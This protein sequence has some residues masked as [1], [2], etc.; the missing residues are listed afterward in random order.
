MCG[1][2]GS[3]PKPLGFKRVHESQSPIADLIFIHG[4]DGHREN[5]WK[6]KDTLWLEWLKDHLPDA[7]VSTY[8][9]NAKIFSAPKFDPATFLLELSKYRGSVRILF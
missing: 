6:S 9:Y 3:Q 4:L 1:C 8:G 5:T 2:C 7:R